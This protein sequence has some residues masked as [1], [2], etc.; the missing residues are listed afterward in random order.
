L[1]SASYGTSEEV[2]GIGGAG[3]GGETEGGGEGVAGEDYTEVLDGFMDLR[4]LKRINGVH[5]S[6]VGLQVLGTYGR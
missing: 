2:C 3:F 6:H 5:D 1:W 4:I